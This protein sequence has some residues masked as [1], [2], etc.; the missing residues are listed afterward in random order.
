VEQVG[1]WEILPAGIAVQPDDLPNCS[2]LTDSPLRPSLTNANGETAVYYL[3]KPVQPDECAF[4]VFLPTGS[5][6]NPD[7]PAQLRLVEGTI[8]GP[9][10]ARSIQ[11]ARRHKTGSSDPDRKNYYDIAIIGTTGAPKISRQ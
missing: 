6:S 1:N 10:G 3:G 8:Q 9:T 7:R 11:L 4:R 2:F 5:L